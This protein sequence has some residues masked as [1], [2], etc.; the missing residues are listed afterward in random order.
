MI[1]NKAYEILE[2]LCQAKNVSSSAKGK[3]EPLTPRANYIVDNILDM[4]LYESANVVMDVYND[5]VD[6]TGTLFYLNIELTFGEGDT[7]VMFIAHHDVNNP[8]SE[9]C[10][11]NSASV[12][13]LLSLAQHLSENTPNKRVHIVFTD[14]EE[15]GGEGAFRLAQRIN[16]GVFGEIEYVVNLELTANGRNLWNDSNIFPEGFESANLLD[17]LNENGEFYIATTPFNDSVVLRNQGIDSICIGS[18]TDDDMQQVIGR[19]YCS[20]WAVCH[21]MNDEFQQANSED[22]DNFVEF[23][24]TLI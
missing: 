17:K 20:T 23:L 14:C 11:D 7:G 16:E 12:A 6:A 5:S 4:N 3:V 24:I 19:G 15:F 13:N 22:M 21:K 2:G 1:R 18:L 10:Q 9:N 8:N